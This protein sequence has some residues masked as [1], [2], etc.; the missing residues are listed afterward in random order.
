[1]KI[2]LD[3]NLAR[4]V[5][6]LEAAGFEVLHWAQVRRHDGRDQEIAPMR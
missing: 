1:V 2:L 4:W 3:M 5:D 6:T